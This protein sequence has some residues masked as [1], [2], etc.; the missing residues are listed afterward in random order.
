MAI[1]RQGESI[2][3]EQLEISIP[4]ISKKIDFL[5]TPIIQISGSDIRK[6]IQ[7]GMQ[8]RYYVPDLVYQYIID[9]KLYQS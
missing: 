6:R 8:F 9:H 2:D 1:D 5:E 7:A 4:E 3:L